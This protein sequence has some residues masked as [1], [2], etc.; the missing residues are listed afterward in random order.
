[1]RRTHGPV[2]GARLGRMGSGRPFLG[3][4]ARPTAH[5]R[6]GI[7]DARRHRAAPGLAEPVLS[8]CCLRYRPPGA[9][10]E[11]RIEALNEA[12]RQGVRTGGRAV[13]SST[14]VRR[15]AIRP[16]FISPPSTPADVQALVDEVLAAGRER[17]GRAAS[18]AP[19]SSSTFQPRA[20]RSQAAPS[21]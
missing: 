1:M 13:T 16:C 7:A 9:A 14:R 18:S 2:V 3:R 19:T 8:T 15:L 11:A 21:G 10:D 17:A 12:V 20:L 5:A 4:A 6:R